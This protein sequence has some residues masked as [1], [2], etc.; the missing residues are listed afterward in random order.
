MP[1]DGMERI[2]KA[3]VERVMR[4]QDIMLQATAKKITWWQAADILGISVR[5]MRRWKWKYERKGMK[6]LFDGRKGKQN[7]RKVEAEEVGKVLGL[8]RDQ[9]HDLNVRHFHE[10]LA[11]EHGIHYSYTWVKNILQ[12]AGLVKK[13][14]G[15]LKHRKR[16]PRRPLPGMMLHI[17][18]S[19]H[20]WFQ[21]DRW[22]DLIVILDDATSE[23]Y[24]A[25]LVA[26]ECTRSVMAAM[27]DVIEHQ[28][29]FASIY[30]DRAG[31]FFQTPKAGGPV[32]PSQLTQVGRAMKDL[33]IRMIPAY[34]PQARGRSERSFG[35]WQGRLPQEL[36]LRSITTL[37]AANDFLRQTYIGEF[38]KKF[39]KPS[40]QTGTAFVL[41]RR[42]DLDRVFSVQHERVVNKDNT[43]R[44][45]NLNLQIE[46]TRIRSTMADSN[47]IVYEHLDG[48]L[49]I[50]YGPHTVGR[51]TA[52]G[53]SLASGPTRRPTREGHRLPLRP[54][55]FAL[56]APLG[57]T[58]ADAPLWSR[59]K[60]KKGSGR[61]PQ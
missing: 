29:W 60:T 7:W 2:P 28:G 45:A 44:W 11:D 48:T 24:Y 37:E 25:Q 33:G 36:R 17:D 3:E 39:S 23:I 52:S 12:G 41:L 46:P 4:V 27:R 58:P 14:R 38:N 1:E 53:E 31:H 26:D 18:G 6:M 57:S 15:R 54:K 13:S 21:D 5:T 47:V 22:Y 9:Y 42:L 10:K 59:T 43:V 34:S 56:R 35:T 40:A 8:Y 32:D 30:S 50:G 51:Y 19:H 20:R 49:S 16:R 61:Q 55:R